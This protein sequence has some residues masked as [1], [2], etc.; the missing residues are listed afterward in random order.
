MLPSLLA[1]VNI[2]RFF[3]KLFQ[4]DANGQPTSF[5]GSAFPITPNG[6]LL[7]C[8]HVVDISI[9]P[10]DSLAV[11]DTETGRFVAIP[12]V[13][14]LRNTQV[15]IAF[16][17]N[18]LQ[19]TKAEFFPVLSPSSLHVGERVYSFGYFTIGRGSNSVEHG[20]FAGSI[21]NFFEHER[22]PAEASFTLPYAVL[23]GMSGSPVL[24]YHNGPKVVGIARGN[25]TSRILAREILQYKDQHI[26][27]QETV[28]RI[29]EFGVAHHCAAIVLF[30]AATGVTGAVISDAEVAVP[31]L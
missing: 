1:V 8:R 11:F 10:G 23:E 18:A 3:Y 28:N 29:V 17:P 6:G 2:E 31:G 4:V 16:V 20:Y 7:T 19:R 13:I 14:F 9:P 26:E 12:T 22:S 30:L 24:T 5:L 27:Y 21:V 25:R 15:D